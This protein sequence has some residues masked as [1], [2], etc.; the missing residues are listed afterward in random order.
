MP[1]DASILFAL[2]DVTEQAALE[3]ALAQSGY[4]IF[5]ASDP[6]ELIKIAEEQHPSVI[7]VASEFAGPGGGMNL[8]RHVKGETRTR[9]IPVVLVCGR[10][11]ALAPT[12]GIDGRPDEVLLRPLHPPEVLIRICAARRLQTYAEEA[13]HGSKLDP[14]T[15][16]FNNA[17]LLDRLRHEVLRAKRYGR[18][19]A[20]VLLDLDRFAAINQREGATFGDLLLR[21][22]ARA[23]TSRLRGVDFVAR[24]GA[25]DFSVVLPETSLLVARPIAERLRLAVESLGKLEGGEERRPLK[26]TASLGI[27]GLPHPEIQEVPDL[28]RCARAALGRARELGG[29][30][31]ELY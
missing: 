18:S 2:A 24:T 29:N 10:S 8:C 23:V 27:A 11:E 28:L 12:T 30:R 31:S 26:V 5:S 13:S 3:G 19:V 25:D 17:Y 15:G 20:L 22:A 9:A 21:E 14:L 16:T 1:M 7:L 6:H 4:K